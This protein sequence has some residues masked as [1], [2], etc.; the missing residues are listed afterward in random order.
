MSARDA[1]LWEGVVRVSKTARGWV[2]AC[3]LACSLLGSAG[4]VSAQAPGGAS[5]EAL[6]ERLD[7]TARSQIEARAAAVATLKTRADAERRQAHV[8][9]TILRLMGGLPQE[10]ADLAVRH[11]GGFQ[12]DGFRLERVIFDS[13]PNFRV[14][15]NVYV[16]GG[17]VG[18]FPAILL[19]PGHSPGGKSELFEFGANLARNGFVTLA[20]DP[21]GQGERLQHY[22]A[23]LGASKVGRPTG[24]HGHASVQV[25]LAGG[26]VSR[27]FVW[28]AMRGL[29]YLSSRADVDA[30]RL[31]AYGCS[32]GGTV[33]A[34]LAALD[35]RVAAAASACYVTTFAQLLGTVGP[36]EGEQSL[37]GFIAE[38]LDF[39]DWVAAA[40]PRP[41]AVVST[42]EDMFP[43]A[44]ARDTFEEARRF[45]GLFGAG[46]RL[47]WITGP[48][49]HGALQPIVGDIVGFF[50]KALKGGGPVSAFSP[51]APVRPEDLLCTETGQVSTSLGGETIHSLTRA[52]ATLLVAPAP[53]VTPGDVDRTRQAVRQA[54]TALAG[55][56][57]VPGGGPPA[58]HV[59][60]TSEREGYRLQSI[61]M[62]TPDGL[63]LPGL[64]AVPG[65][66]GRR[67]VVVLFDPES[68]ASVGHPG[69]D[70]DRLARA[71]HLVLAFA[72]RPSPAGTEEL[73]AP[74][75]GTSYLLSLRAF[76]VGRTILGMRVDDALAAL[77][78]VASREDVDVGRVTVYGRGSAGPVVLHAAALDTRV[79]HV[80]VEQGL[81]AYRM[82]VD[83]PLHRNVSEVVVPGVLGRYDLVDLA[84][85]AHPRRVTMVGPVDAVGSPLRE[86]AFR[87]VWARVFEADRALGSSGR[88]RVAWRGPREPLSID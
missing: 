66:T 83:Q 87:R 36:Q 38:G 58:V 81:A 24:E 12:G 55:V 9:Q 18:P 70:L 28:D 52:R 22:D 37:P 69:P 27:Y 71:G 59:L 48:G 78:V 86:D 63:Q 6:I 54:I 67:P 5:R 50:V 15:A 77:D 56:T 34:Y 8:R 75:L 10:R 43:F 80:V 20:W 21:V 11:V 82:V 46:E 60:A 30:S 14:T 32:G 7:A 84:I 19:S 23:E 47:Q 42:T 62:T 64:L 41:Y 26:H 39:A 16:P 45:Y 74:L 49:G 88:V 57:A 1:P 35:E 13:L 53:V 17:G 76:L 68:R 31:G 85:A 29:D 65:G 72:P 61:A 2:A 33:T 25:M 51:V 40:A 4:D 3:A 44:G 73:K 79:A